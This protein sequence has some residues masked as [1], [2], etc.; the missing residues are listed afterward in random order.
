M[1][2]AGKLG[3]TDSCRSTAAAFTG[4]VRIMGSAGACCRAVGS[5]SCSRSSSGSSMLTMDSRED[6]LSNRLQS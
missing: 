6:A 5:Y 4:L 1:R 2:V 3:G